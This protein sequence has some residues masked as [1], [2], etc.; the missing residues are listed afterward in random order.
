MT[1]FGL[2]AVGAEQTIPERD[3]KTVIAIGFPRY[4]GVMDTVHVWRHEDVP[5][6]AVHPRGQTD[7]AMIEHGAG[8]E[9]D[10]KEQ[11]GFGWRAY[12]S[13]RREL[14]AHGN[15]NFNR[16]EAK[17]GRDVDLRIGVVDSMQ[18]P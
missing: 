7:I 5:Q 16:M 11:D 6:K 18:P 15:H 13:H 4:C 1:S 8:V 14:N 2:R 3:V 12:C 9:D 17:S 10:L